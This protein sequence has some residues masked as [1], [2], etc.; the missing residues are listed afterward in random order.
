MADKIFRM[1]VGLLVGAYVARYLGPERFGV[2]SYAR[3]LVGLFI[4][5]ASLGLDGIVV[6]ET[7]TKNINTHELLGTA[8]I[9]KNIG[10]VLMFV[11]I[12]IALLLSHNNKL[13]NWLVCII[14]TSV[15]FHSFNV[16]NS[17][18][19]ANVISKY[20]VWASLLSMFSS[21]IIKVFL[22]FNG[23]SLV[24]FA[25]ASV[26][27]AM[28]LTTGYLFF[29]FKKKHS[30]FKWRINLHV[31]L[32]LVKESWVLLFSGY[33]I[34]VCM[35][36]DKILIR[37]FHSEKDVGIYSAATTL[38]TIWYF[39]V[40]SFSSGIAPFL[41]SNGDNR[42]QMRKLYSLLTLVA[43]IITLLMA[44]FSDIIVAKLYGSEYANSS[45]I[46]RIHILS[47]VFVFS[48]SMRKK[49]FIMR[50]KIKFLL[51]YG[52]FTTS[53]NIILNLILI[54]RYAGLG[55][56]IAFVITWISSAIVIPAFFGRFRE[57]SLLFLSSLNFINSG[58]TIWRKR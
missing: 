56:A 54:P 31:A 1:A 47:L 11:L 3:S 32:S 57:D 58:W 9:L 40:V 28:V 7:A 51:V 14:T 50:K 20:A 22:I 13:T 5:V 55:A 18:F 6:R 21:S 34:A 33:L 45:P 46:L 36:L 17:Y 12:S 35:N 48:V 37:A 42:T 15:L 16:I 43:I 39:L 41:V 44:F 29:Y 53:I 24:W 19:Q 2:L 4:I 49:I 27:E 52:I 25:I 8:F 10:F 23:A 26:I 38:S 30:P